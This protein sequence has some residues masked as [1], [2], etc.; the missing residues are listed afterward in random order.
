MRDLLLPILKNSESAEVFS[1]R[2]ITG[3]TLSA[4]KNI[5][6]NVTLSQTSRLNLDKFGVGNYIPDC[7]SVPFASRGGTLHN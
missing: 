1:S 3:K 4:G 5:T 2:E 6:G 7:R